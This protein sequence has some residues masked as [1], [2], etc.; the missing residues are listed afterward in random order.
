MALVEEDRAENI[1]ITPNGSG[2]TEQPVR[3]VELEAQ[4]EVLLGYVLDR[5]GWCNHA[6]ALSREL[7]QQRHSVA[8]DR[9]VFEIRNRLN[10]AILIF[11]RI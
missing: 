1:G 8:L 10:H 5:D 2:D 9:L 11:I 7:S 4:L 3:I 6:A